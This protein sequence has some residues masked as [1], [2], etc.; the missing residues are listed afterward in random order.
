MSRRTPGRATRQI[1]SGDQLSP[2]RE[3]IGGRDPGAQPL[4]IAFL[5]F[6]AL[7]VL[8]VFCALVW[9]VWGMGPASVLLLLLAVAL[10]AAWLV[11]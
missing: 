3:A 9:A 6:V 11:L 2:P 7:A 8:V 1:L 10:I 5:Y 4:P